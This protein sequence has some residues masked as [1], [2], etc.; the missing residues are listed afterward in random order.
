MCST[1]VLMYDVWSVTWVDGGNS[2]AGFEWEAVRIVSHCGSSSAWLDLKRVQRVHRCEIHCC[3]LAVQ[4]FL[5]SV[6]VPKV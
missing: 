3:L 4:P 2:A 1:R 5:C 6:C